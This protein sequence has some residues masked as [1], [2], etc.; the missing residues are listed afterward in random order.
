MATFTERNKRINA[1]FPTYDAKGAL[2]AL[3]AS[4]EAELVDENG[5]VVSHTSGSVPSVW[6][7]F[8]KELQAAAQTMFAAGNAALGD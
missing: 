5:E 7:G 6:A 1:V 8:S 2:V 3:T 4:W